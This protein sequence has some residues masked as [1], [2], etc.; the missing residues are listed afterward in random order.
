MSPQINTDTEQ[1]L[2][3]NQQIIDQALSLISAHEAEG[4][5]DY[6]ALV[7]P[8]LRH[9]I[10]HYEALVMP[11]CAGI[12]DYDNRAR[13]QDVERNSAVA[14]DRLLSIREHLVTWV[15]SG[16]DTP[17]DIHG[18]GGATGEFIFAVKSTVGRELVFVASHAVHHFALLKLYCKE[19]GI[20]T[21]TN[22]GQAPS[23]VAHHLTTNRTINSNI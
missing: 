16:M 15:M 10:E 23:T 5:T 18:V 7:G 8:H 1:L 11:K 21:D 3:F 4:L 20:L 14:R 12:A 6:A 9:V 17:I 13:D 2:R 22:F 19:H